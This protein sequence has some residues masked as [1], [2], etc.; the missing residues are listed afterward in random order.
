MQKITNKWRAITEPKE[1]DKM[2]YKMLFACGSKTED[3][4]LKEC[5]EQL[6]SAK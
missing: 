5:M 1:Y 3:N 2:K 6:D 4:L